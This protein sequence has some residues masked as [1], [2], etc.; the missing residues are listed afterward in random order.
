MA[1]LGRTWSVLFIVG[2]TCP[3][4]RLV[5]FFLV[6]SENV[7]LHCLWDLPFALPGSKL[8]IACLISRRDQN[9]RRLSLARR[10]LRLPAWTG[11]I[12]ATEGAFGFTVRTI[13]MSKLSAEGCVSVKSVPYPGIEYPQVISV[14][15]RWGRGT[16]HPTVAFTRTLN[17]FCFS[18]ALRTTIIKLIQLNQHVNRKVKNSSAPRRGG[19][20]GF[21]DA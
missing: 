9:R 14:W 17:F 19:S 11:R 10:P 8:N 6:D 16:K 15:K 13:Q 1:A 4:F 5:L 7:S 20:K 18:V 12:P 3:E 21:Y 2:L